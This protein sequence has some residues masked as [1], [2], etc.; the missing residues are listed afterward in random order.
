[1]DFM[2]QD[3]ISLVIVPQQL[4]P[5]KH[6]RLCYS[7]STRN[8]CTSFSSAIPSFLCYYAA[9]GRLWSRDGR[10]PETS[11]YLYMSTGRH[12][13]C[14][15]TVTIVASSSFVMGIMQISPDNIDGRAIHTRRCD[16]LD[17]LSIGAAYSTV[18]SKIEKNARKRR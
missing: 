13:I 11:P 3:G 8:R 6:Q 7:Q 12:Q 15:F 9:I 10:Q 4:H 14:S 5:C 16:G 17:S 1:M 18:A 2:R